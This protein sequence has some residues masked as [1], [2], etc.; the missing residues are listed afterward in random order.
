MSRFIACVFCCA[1]M[2]PATS[3]AG[4]V[5]F[6]ADGGSA[7]TFGPDGSLHVVDTNAVL[8]RGVMTPLNANGAVF[9]EDTTFTLN[10]G[11][12]ISGSADTG[13][14]FAGGGDFTITG[15]KTFGGPLLTLASAPLGAFNL[16]RVVGDGGVIHYELDPSISPPTAVVV[17]MDPSIGAFYG[18]F[19]FGVGGIGGNFEFGVN[20]QLMSL[21]LTS[22]VFALD[23]PPPPS[24]VPE[25]GSAL[26]VVLAM[27]GV[28]VRR[29]SKGIAGVFRA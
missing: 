4:F 16:I 7:A 9:V 21:G 10:L 17:T 13:Y 15:R 19:P 24:S 20:G 29:F 26:M 23:A 6:E 8:I 18:V 28:A 5:Q 27:G 25:P 3:R 12:L 1:F 22:D 11:P 14:S 2:F